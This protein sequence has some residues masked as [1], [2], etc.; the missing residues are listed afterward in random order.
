MNVL[1]ANSTLNS[2]SPAAIAAA[3]PGGPVDILLGIGGAPEGVLAAAALTAIGGG[4]QGEMVWRSDAERER[5]IGMGIG[6][7]DRIFD[8][9]D[10]V[11]GDCVF[12]ASGVTDGDFLKG[13][14][15]TARGAKTHSVVMRSASGTVRWLE[16][17]HDFRRGHGRPYLT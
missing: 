6:D 10:M 8:L 5:A 15:F 17:D 3:V 16:A 7:P 2:S 11:R 12:V 13:V 1:P 14:Q 9:A 4:M